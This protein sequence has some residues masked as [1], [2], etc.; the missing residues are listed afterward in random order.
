MNPRKILIVGGGSTGWLTAAHLHSVLNR[1]G[2]E[3]VSISVLESPETSDSGVGE[4]TLPNINRILAILGVEQQEFMRRVDGSFKQG[5]KFVNW[6]Y[7]EEEHFYHPFS[8]PRSGTVDRSGQRWLKSNRSV[9]FAETVSAQPML[10][11]QNLSPRM[12]GRWD[13]GPPLTYA[14]HIDE[15]KFANYLC[16][17][18]TAR[19]VTQHPGHIA[20]VEMA[21]NGDIAAVNSNN[22]DRLEADLYIDCTGS[23]ALLSEKEMGV[24]WVDCSEWL[25]CDR[26]LTIR[27]PYEQYY[28]GY[29]H[30]YT[31][32]TAL[33][34]GWTWDIPLQDSRS[35][36][37]VYS[38][39]FLGEEEADRE[40][41]FLEGSH[42]DSLSSTEIQFKTGHRQNAWVGNCISI[43]AA[44]GFI[45][46]L[47]S[48]GLHMI[49]VAAEMLV[50]HFPY[51]DETGPLAYRYNRIMVNRFYEILDFVN[52][53]YCLTRRTDTDFW[54]E[55]QRPERINE[56]LRAKLDFWRVKQP[57]PMD[58][59]DQFF[60]GQSDAPLPSSNVPGDYRGPVDTASLWD[61]ENYEVVLYG[62]DFLNKECD[63]WFGEQRPNS[64]VSRQVVERLRLAPQKLPPHDVWLQQV[65]GMPNY[66]SS[67][68]MRKQ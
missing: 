60:P 21:E 59:E 23:A 42:A 25:L 52:L 6:L 31:T 24:G 47:E 1:D 44:S 39:A 58:F 40:L 11:E 10:C 38:S 67:Q 14:F 36:G 68:R 34:A 4:S 35:L 27:V 5:S 16:V 49:D 33:S 9:P 32:A 7:N 51:G 2:R 43:G 28:P 3:L 61:Y 57:T 19:G 41:R 53:H 29:V 37:Y 66:Q 22:G 50:E 63:D 8:M 65:C 55:V 13:F 30:P 12:L 62:M 15:L 17:L 26:A 54:R 56:R 46:S 64:S 18:L 20:A 48:T 45:E